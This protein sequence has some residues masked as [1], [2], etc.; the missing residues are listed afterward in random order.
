MKP[1]KP[2]IKI[3]RNG[4]VTVRLSVSDLCMMVGDAARGDASNTSSNCHPLQD[5]YQK[6]AD[7]LAAWETL[8]NSDSSHVFIADDVRKVYDV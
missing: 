4:V 8:W 5:T 3:A 6:F 2:S 7:E 1:I